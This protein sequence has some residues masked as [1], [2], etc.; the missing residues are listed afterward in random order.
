M[1]AGFSMGGTVA[2]WTA[3]QA[4]SC[5]GRTFAMDVSQ[6]DKFAVV[7][8]G[9]YAYKYASNYYACV[10]IMLITNHIDNIMIMS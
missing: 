7:E 8:I 10:L 1:L 4:R 6:L 5:F 9:D 2:A 3:L